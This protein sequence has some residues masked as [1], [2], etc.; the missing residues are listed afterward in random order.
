MTKRL[1]KLQQRLADQVLG[2]EEAALG[3][4]IAILAKGHVLLE[5]PPGVGKTMIAQCLADSIAGSCKRVQFTPDLLPSDIIGYSLYRQ[6]LDSFE[7]VKGPVFSNVLLADEINRTSPRVQS[8]LLEAMSEHQVSVDGDTFALAEP[9]LVIA[10]QNDISYTGTFPLPEAQL[11]RFF[12]SIPM[13]LPRRNVQLKILSGSDR[14]EEKPPPLLTLAQI[15]EL[16]EAVEHVHVGKNV[17]EYIVD[18]CEGV[19][20]LAG[21][22]HA[23][24][25]RAS[26]HLLRAARALALIDG[27]DYVQPDHVQKLMSVVLAHRVITDDGSDVYEII[28]A[29][30]DKIPVK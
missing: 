20:S 2:A 14:A 1:K 25:V 5:G 18:L 11:D 19:R 22:P 16:Q 24:S 7:F 13:S 26:K 6:Q 30:L 28:D 23:L 4:C 29:V 10:T 15:V 27:A 21:G 12:M 3:L 8:A 9:F 17:I